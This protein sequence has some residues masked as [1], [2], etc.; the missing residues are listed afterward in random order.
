MYR[1]IKRIFDLLSALALFIVISPLYLLLMM[2][3]R[4]RIGTPIY[5][6]QV[7]TG[8][9]G[10]KFSIKK[11]RSMTEERDDV[12]NYLPDEQRL[13][14]LGNWLRRTSLD[15][16]PELLCIIRGE[17]SV[18]G[19]RPLPPAYDEYYTEYEKKRFNVRGGL[20]PPEVLYRDIEP[21]W[22]N[23]LRYEADYAE[24][25]SAGLDIKILLAALKGVFTRYNNDYGEYVRCPLSEER[26]EKQK[27][28]LVNDSINSSA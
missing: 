21:S 24:N 15:E 23:Q 4:F 12:G 10:E 2:L 19:P 1:F 5:F 18:I 6:S 9:H 8:Y 3:V 22:D 27:G 16:L 28:V 25:L 11:F 13:T 14:K 17:M 20:V 7:R 26:A